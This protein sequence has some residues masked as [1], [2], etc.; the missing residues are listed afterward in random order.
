MRPQG[1]RRVAGARGFGDFRV[2][3]IHGAHLMPFYGSA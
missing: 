2:K 3:L 1:R